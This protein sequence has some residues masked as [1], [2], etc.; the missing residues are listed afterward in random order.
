MC[1][2]CTINIL[3]QTKVTFLD[4]KRSYFVIIALSNH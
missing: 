3:V 1:I 2:V 4:Y